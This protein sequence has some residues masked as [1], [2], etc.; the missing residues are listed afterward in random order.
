MLSFNGLSA[1]YKCCKRFTSSVSCLLSAVS[2]LLSIYID[3]H[4]I[5]DLGHGGSE[6]AKW[7]KVIQDL[8]GLGTGLA[9]FAKLT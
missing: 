7:A 9:M 5:Q 6:W 3:L 2:C 4:E 1:I 8:Q